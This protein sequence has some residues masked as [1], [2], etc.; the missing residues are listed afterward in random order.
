MRR[1]IQSFLAYAVRDDCRRFSKEIKRLTEGR[2]QFSPF[3]VQYD[4]T[5]FSNRRFS[6]TPVCGTDR[7]HLSQ[8]QKLCALFQ[9]TLIGSFVQ[10]YLA[11]VAGPAPAANRRTVFQSRLSR[12]TAPSAFESVVK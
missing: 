9:I 5:K 8:F 3:Q 1:R 4:S 6:C 10:A 7:P 11:K 12:R 2:L